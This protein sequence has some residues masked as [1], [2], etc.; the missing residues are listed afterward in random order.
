MGDIADYAR[1][2]PPVYLLG[3]NAATS[4]PGGEASARD[5]A[6]GSAWLRGP[7]WDLCLISFCWVPFAVWFVFGLGLRGARLDAE[8]LGLATLVALAITYVHR[9]LTFVLVYGDPQTFATR[10]RAF[11]WVPLFVFAGCGLVLH[12]QGDARI[13]VPGLAFSMRPWFLILIVTGAWNMWHTL[14]QRHGLARIYAKKCH[15]LTA[16]AQHAKRDRTLLWSLALWTAIATVK[17]QGPSF[18]SLRNARRMYATLSPI[19]EG[20]WGWILWGASSAWLLWVVWRWARTERAAF[21]DG[22]N[23]WP[24]ACFWASNLALFGCFVAFG[25]VVGYLA[26]GTAHALEYIAFFHH[27]GAAKFRRQPDNRSVAA[28]LLRQPKL[29]VLPM[30]LALLAAFWF[31]REHRR[32][33]IYVAYYTAT[34]LLHFLFDGWIWKVRRPEVAKPLGADRHV[35]TRTRKSA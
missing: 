34:S 3:V 27:F 8:A 5:D 14:M 9:H 19:V 30:A 33:E 15:P 21:R 26:F 6:P 12:V 10:K 31:L 16:S 29:T 17:V 28:R 13:R 1:T 4:A 22:A 23:L 11:A 7:A 24:R 32:A 25:P 18:A 20:A 2:R 35:D